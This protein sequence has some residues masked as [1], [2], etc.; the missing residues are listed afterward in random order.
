LSHSLSFEQ[1]KLAAAAVLLSPYSPLLFMGEEYGEQAPFLYFVSHLDPGLA[2][3]VRR[4]RR[5]EFAAF[6]WKV[7]P[8]DPQAEATFARCKLDRALK[9]TRRGRALWNFYRRLIEIRKHQPAFAGLNRDR[10]DVAVL[11]DQSVALRIWSGSHEIAIALHFGKSPTTAH[12]AVPD[13]VWVKQLDS[14]QE[15]WLGPG[16]AVPDRARSA[17]A[18]PLP[19]SAHSVVAFTRDAGT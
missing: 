12:L 7:E 17:G 2:E 18:L 5:A 6:G 19:L 9:H 11:S 16:S 15:A 4:G 13:G 10:I 3:A 8:S 14:A 1:Q